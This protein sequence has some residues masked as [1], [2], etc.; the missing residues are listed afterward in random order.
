L[1]YTL[2]KSNHANIHKYQRRCFIR[3]HST[4]WTLAT[5][6]LYL[7]KNW[8]NINVRTIE[9]IEFSWTLSKFK[10][11]KNSPS[12]WSIKTQNQ[13]N[14]EKFNFEKTHSIWDQTWHFLTLANRPYFI[15]CFFYFKDK[16]CILSFWNFYPLLFLWV[17]K[18][19]KKNLR[20]W[21]WK[22]EKMTKIFVFQPILNCFIILEKA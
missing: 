11:K 12:G 21:T 13:K 17:F 4:I 2:E 3:N 9:L 6:L 10:K 16:N 7:K 14:W 22:Q 19:S 18:C 20:K 1:Q 8:Y 15:I 5:V